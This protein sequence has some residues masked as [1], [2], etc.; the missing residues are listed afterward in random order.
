MCV[1]S[2]CFYWST[3]GKSK[4]TKE[5]SRTSQFSLSGIGRVSVQLTVIPPHLVP[6]SDTEA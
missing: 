5:K 3:P 1:S 2:L 6:D 4:E